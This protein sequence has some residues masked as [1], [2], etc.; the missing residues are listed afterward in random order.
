MI[1]WLRSMFRG[2]GKRPGRSQNSGQVRARYESAQT[3]AENQPLWSLTDFLSA[4]AANS[5]QV[6]RTLKIRSRYEA[7]NNSYFR[8]IIDTLAN[9][10]IGT[11]PR[12]QVRTPSSAINKAVQQRWNGWCEACG[13]AE[14]LRTLAKAKVQDGEG[15]A[16]AVLNRDLQDEVKLDWN[17]I[18]SD[19]VTTPDPGF[20]DYFWVDGIV[21]NK[22]GNPAEYHILRHHPGDLFVPQLNPLVYDRWPVNR[23]IHWFRKDRPGQARGIPEV[24]PSLEL[25]AQLRRYTKAV[26]GAAEIAADFAAVLESNAPPDPDEEDLTPFTTTQIDRGVMT[27]LPAN[28]KLSQFKP[29]Q[30]ATTYEMFV[31]IILREIC[32]CLQIPLNIAMG[33][34]AMMNY[35]S[36]RLDHL[37][38]H[39]GQRVQR[40]EC[41]AVV[42]K[43]LY[44]SWYEEAR[45]I[46][47]YLPEG[48][49]EEAP[50]HRWFWDSAES[51]DPE[52]DANAE[53][54]QLD[55]HTV[56]LEEI[57]AEKG[58][59]W[60]DRIRQRGREVKLMEELGLPV[61]TA[62]KIL[63]TQKGKANEQQPEENTA[64]RSS[65]HARF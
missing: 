13:L 6:R 62:R 39:R 43:K 31:R 8:G 61:E 47:G 15:F 26:I 65:S 60:E 10:L 29:E 32:R 17:L 5:F 49:P 46:R 57:Y 38:Y 30:P 45:L 59:D 4:R 42:L 40:S 23:V 36:G 25:F 33:D 35:S 41:G 48:M 24:T 12:L 51:I 56:T 11:G 7:A 50:P 19:Q 27:E 16:I 55:G 2:P 54:V 58:E 21:L 28:H 18:E 22:L 52:K 1:G 53:Q 20:I 37:G 44:G 9:D 3:N 14:K 34:S 63:D 64:G